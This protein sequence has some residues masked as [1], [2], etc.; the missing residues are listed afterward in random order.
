MEISLQ[1]LFMPVSSTAPWRI[2]A[3]YDKANGRFEPLMDVP[4]SEAYHEFEIS[5]A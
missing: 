3:S 1:R 5:K 4:I 2:R